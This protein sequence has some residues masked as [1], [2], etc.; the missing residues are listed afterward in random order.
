MNRRDKIIV[1]F[2]AL[3]LIG[4]GICA[5]TVIDV[6]FQVKGVLALANGG[7]GLNA[8]PGTAG[9]LLFNNSGVLAAE[10]P[11]ISYNYANLLTTA[12]ATATAS[13][14]SPVRLSR[15]SGF[16]TLYV[17]FASITGSPLTCTLQLK[18]ADSLGN[19]INNGSPISVTPANG[20]TTIAV[21]SASGLQTAAQLSVTFACGTYPTAGTISV[22]YVQADTV[23]IAGS[24]PAGTNS[25]GG[26]K[27][28]DSAGTGYI[29]DPCQGNAHTTFSINQA[30]GTQLI[31]GTS[32]KKIYICS[33]HV[34]TA[35]AQNIAL[36][37]GT[38]TVCASGTAGLKGFG[39]STAATG[40][41]FAANGG[42]TYGDGSYQIGTEATAADNVCLLQSST[43]QVSGGGSYV[44][45]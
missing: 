3:I 41:N 38:G 17:T 15:F 40:Q 33:Y 35:T 2:A 7:T 28:S 32:G 22:D 5:V 10:D 12:V 16:G 43:G 45:Q 39:G 44:L 42:E 31:A 6:S 13:T 21:N 9:Q 25:I 24:L 19:L 36:V 27:L 8:L 18:N 1:T 30:T 26:V 4:M 37:E 14:S 20:I 29:V 23:A 34:V 11:I